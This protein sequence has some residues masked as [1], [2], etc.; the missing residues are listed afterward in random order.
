VA[1][2]PTNQSWSRT[3]SFGWVLFAYLLALAC[4]MLIASEPGSGPLASLAW[5]YTA[6]LFVLWAFTVR[7]DNGSFVDPAW[8]VGPPLIAIYWILGADGAASATRQIAVTT[9][10][11]LWGARLT[12]N[13]ARGWSGLHHEDWRYL[14]LYDQVP[15][16]KWVVSLVAIY[17]FPSLQV[18]IG[19]LSLIPALAVGTRS[20]A[21]L[22]CVAL[23]VTGGAILIE[24]IADEQLRAFA[25]DKKPGDILKTGLWGRSRHPNYFGEIGFWWGLYLF[26]LAA[27]PGWW[28][29]AIGPLSMTLM[30]HFASIPMLDRRSVERRPGYA[31]H[32]R[33]VNAIIP[34]WR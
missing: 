24:T 12:W 22:D 33:R 2:E 28:W 11:F 1:D 6:A 20:F 14:D 31:E 15:A 32:M 17:L 18:F 7:F 16:P 4:A 34:R 21:A 30:F 10:V 9:L 29:T 5:G 8:S 3:D 19:C 13:W 25:R 23:V 27:D 26:G